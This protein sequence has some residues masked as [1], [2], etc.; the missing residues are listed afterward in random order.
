MTNPP[1]PAAENASD[2]NETRPGAE[3]RDEID[4]R[5][6][7]AA[8]IL[9]AGPRAGSRAGA[10]AFLAAAL[11]VAGAVYYYMTGEGELQRLDA[12]LLRH[13]EL[14]LEA[15]GKSDAVAVAPTCTRRR[16]RRRRTCGTS[17]RAAARGATRSS[18]TTD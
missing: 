11:V 8:E 10:L 6:A 1:L 18:C 2:D 13:A 7:E 5:P 9:A 14:S 3:A 12:A 4:A 15:D 16:R 17:P